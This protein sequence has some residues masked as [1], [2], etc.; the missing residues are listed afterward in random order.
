MA[1]TR[2]LPSVF[3]P[4]AECNTM[5][6]D[7]ATTVARCMLEPRCAIA[8]TSE[9]KQVTV[10]VPFMHFCSNSHSYSPL[11]TAS[12]VSQ[13]LHVVPLLHTRV[14]PRRIYAIHSGI[15]LE[16]AGDVMWT[17]CKERVSAFFACWNMILVY[18]NVPGQYEHH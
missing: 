13:C 15:D 8:T 6:V 11:S 1:K 17:L 5:L 7:P 14:T 2:L 10:H 16:L 18:G 9:A 12:A 4:I 3:M